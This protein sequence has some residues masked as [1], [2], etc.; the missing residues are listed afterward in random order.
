M[1][2]SKKYQKRVTSPD[3]VYHSVAIN[4]FIGKLMLNGKKLK[5]SNFVYSAFKLL[6]EKLGREDI[7]QMFDDCIG[8]LYPQHFLRPWRIAS[9]IYPLPYPIKDPLVANKKA[10]HW[11]VKA[12]RRRKERGLIEKIYSE[13]KDIFNS[14]GLALSF[15]QKHKELAKEYEAYVHYGS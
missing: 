4:R 1:N 10:I 6:S 8:F 3:I 9:K 7:A 11:L 12:I 15:L 14:T 2:R 13:M 5:I